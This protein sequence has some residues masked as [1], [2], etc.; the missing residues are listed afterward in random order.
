MHLGVDGEILREILHSEDE[1]QLTCIWSE[2]SQGL[3]RTH[4]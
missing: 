3:E 4:I 1:L 2:R